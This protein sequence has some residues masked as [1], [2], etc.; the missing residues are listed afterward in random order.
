VNAVRSFVSRRRDAEEGFTLIELM[1][2]VLIIAILIAIA[3]PQFLGARERAEDRA[4]QSSLRNALT[5]AK[6]AY[7]D[8]QSYGAATSVD[9]PAIEPS[10]TYVVAGTSSTG[11]KEVSVSVTNLSGTDQQIWSAAALSKSGK[12]FWIK[13]VATGVATA[14]TFYGSVAGPTCTGTAA[15]AAAG[16]SW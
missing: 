11:F 12:C 8:A 5:A 9:L 1:V 10:L 6:T 13:D 7:T 3:I 2:V 14:G 15:T 4:A 16:T